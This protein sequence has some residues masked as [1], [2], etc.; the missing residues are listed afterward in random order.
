MT[1]PAGAHIFS[2][3]F[4]IRSFGTIIRRPY[5]TPIPEITYTRFHHD[6]NG[7][8]EA[9]TEGHPDAWM[10]TIPSDR[11]CRAS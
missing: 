9:D 3:A 4:H 6:R 10:V 11:R 7:R 5:A 1:M 2:V 8:F